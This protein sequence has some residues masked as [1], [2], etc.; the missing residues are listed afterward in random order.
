[1][2]LGDGE[3]IMGKLKFEEWIFNQAAVEIRNLHGYNGIFTSDMFKK[4]FDKKYQ[5]QS[6]SG[7]GAQHQNAKAERDIQTIMNIAR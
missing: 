2:S 3:T 6:F 7:A 5:S 4:G 1:M